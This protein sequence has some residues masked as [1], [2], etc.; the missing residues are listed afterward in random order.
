[1]PIA[2]DCVVVWKRA[3]EPSSSNGLPDDVARADWLLAESR[4]NEDFSVVAHSLNLAYAAGG[5]MPPH[6]AQPDIHLADMPLLAHYVVMS[7]DVMLNYSERVASCAVGEEAACLEAELML[8]H[9]ADTIRYCR[10]IAQSETPDGVFR[11]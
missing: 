10:T 5:H 1:M 11:E 8:V 6:A 9:R 4:S 3:S 7:R 2:K